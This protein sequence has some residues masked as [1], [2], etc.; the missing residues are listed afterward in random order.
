MICKYTDLNQLST[1][2]HFKEELLRFTQQTAQKLKLNYQSTLQAVQN[3][4]ILSRY[5]GQ[6]INIHA[7][8]VPYCFA[9]ALLSLASKIHE[10]YPPSL[11]MLAKSV[12]PS[13]RDL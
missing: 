7:K 8:D 1:N 10:K 5:R 11:K 12:H 4:N 2:M 6:L 13:Y 3:I 9:L